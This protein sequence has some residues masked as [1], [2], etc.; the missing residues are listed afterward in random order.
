MRNR[1]TAGL[2]A[3]SVV[4]LGLVAPA[5]AG[6]GLIQ[7]LSPPK[8]KAAKK[9]SYNLSCSATCSL[10]A[11]LTL[12]LKHGTLGPVT[13]GPQQFAAGQ[14][15]SPYIILNN[16]AKRDLKANTKQARLLTTITAV[17]LDPAGGGATDT[18]DRTFKF[19]K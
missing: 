14:G 1:R 19:K 18:V 13:V 16:V 5:A 4:A 17:N 9:V 7:V 12:K 11:E 6:T 2:V 8:L 3:T 15:G 10:T